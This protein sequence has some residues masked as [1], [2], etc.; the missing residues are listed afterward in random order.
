MF[1]P[2]AGF[3]GYESGSGF[4]MVCVGTFGSYWSCTPD[5]E[6]AYSLFLSPD[7]F[8]V[9]VDSNNRDCGSSVRLVQ[10]LVPHTPSFSV[11]A[12]KKVRF[13]PGNLQAV[14][15]AAGNTFTW[16]FAE[17]QWNYVGNAAANTSIDGDGSV[18]AAG[19]VDLFGWSTPNT[20]YGINNKNISDFDDV[21]G[22]F[23]D[24]G[25]N[26]GLIAA[27]GSGWRTL[28]S[29]EWTYLLDT[30][31]G[32]RYCNATVNSVSGLVIFPDGYSHPS[33]VTVPTSVNT[34]GAGYTSNS[35]SGTAWTAM[36]A[37]GCVFLPAAGFRAFETGSGF[38]IDDVGTLGVYWSCTPDT[39]DPQ[40]AY[41]LYLIPDD[42]FVVV[43]WDHRFSGNSVRLVQDL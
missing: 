39:D 7:D 24:W 33:G 4:L 18:S 27:L 41:T 40:K 22:D 26:S 1:L 5:T 34:P 29:A 10:D 21:S 17:R 11:S 13:S 12:A 42:S 43:D 32:D 16:K 37:A 36:E 15:A 38:S 30:R 3:R 6:D 14:F 9:G 8:L 25:S 23:V 28:S 2:A 31:D 35:W 20:T 19:T